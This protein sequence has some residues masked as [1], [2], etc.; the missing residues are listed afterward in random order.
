MAYSFVLRTGQVFVEPS[1]KLFRK[2][3]Y[4]RPQ[5]E[6]IAAPYPVDRL[7]SGCFPCCRVSRR[8]EELGFE[9]SGP[10]PLGQ[11]RHSFLSPVG[12]HLRM[13]ALLCRRGDMSISTPALVRGVV[14]LAA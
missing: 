4:I 13:L 8:G 9:P 14:T 10:Y 1:A 5:L 11:V 7:S 3:E 2:A 12:E 6:V